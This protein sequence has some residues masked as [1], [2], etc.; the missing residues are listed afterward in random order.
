M[1]K[2]SRSKE[3]AVPEENHKPVDKSVKVYQKDKIKYQLHIAERDD[4]TDK[5]KELIDLI[6]NKHTKVVFIQGPAGTS[7]SF[8]A[9]YA[10]LKLVNAKL[11]SD[12]VYVRS[13]IE[14]ASRS[15]GA[16]P[17]EISDKL[18]P[19]LMP[20]HEKLDELLP[21]NEIDLLAKEDRIQGIPIGFLRGA[22]INA[23][24]VVIDE[25]QNL[26]YKELTT[27]LTRIGKYSKFI[28]LGDPFQSDLPHDKSGFM[29]MYEKFNTEAARENGIHCFAFTNKDIVRSGI[30]RFIVETIEGVYV[31][32]EKE[33]PMFP[34]K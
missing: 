22:S 11:V 30:L 12:L 29:K 17:G 6:L 9:I 14:S 27:A 21:K 2:K 15:L 28:V 3:A 32:P 8:T 34:P 20:F 4:F 24:F 1:G 31:P 23:K 18:N 25:A 26:D 7:K 13:V 5:Q 19:F 10:G 16:L 33:E